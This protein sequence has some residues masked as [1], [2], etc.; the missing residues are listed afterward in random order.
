MQ[1]IIQ[2][3]QTISSHIWFYHLQE[4]IGHHKMNTMDEI[5]L[6]GL[7]NIFL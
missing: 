1:N 7:E 6:E 4:L 2:A 5:I 3:Q